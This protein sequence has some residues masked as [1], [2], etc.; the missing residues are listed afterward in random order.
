LM[1]N[2]LLKAIVGK[3]DNAK[4]VTIARQE[5]ML[6]FVK[7]YLLSVQT[8]N[9]PAVNEAINQLLIE[10][11]DYEALR[12]SIDSYDKFDPIALARALEKH[13][14]VEFRRIAAILYKR[15]GQWAQ[16]VELSKRDELF[17]DAM[18]SAAESADA[19]VVEKLLR[20]FVDQDNKECFAACLYT[21][22]DFV[23]PDV[24]MEVAWKKGYTDFAMPYFIQVIKEYTTKV[25]ELSKEHAAAASDKEGG[26]P[27]V[28]QFPTPVVG[29]PAVYGYGS[30]PVGLMPPGSMGMPPMG[31][32]G[33]PMGA[34]GSA[35][36]MGVMGGFPS[37]VTPPHSGGGFGFM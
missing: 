4:V 35:P 28:T 22:Y 27:P 15:N 18:K 29:D 26:T 10:E 14:L 36:I 24:V 21:C 37:S 32:M 30:V 31:M 20:F 16:S 1:V 11:D 33:V 3:V 9:V 13:E 7:P 12:H 8:D 23:R 34:P 19:D 5:S 17:S 25:D 2:D 6:D